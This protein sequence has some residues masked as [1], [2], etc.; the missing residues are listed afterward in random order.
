MGQVWCLIVSIPDLCTLAYFS[1]SR[2]CGLVAQG[3]TLIFSC[4]RGIGSFL[5]VQNFEFQYNLGGFQKNKYFLEYE[6]FVDIFW[7]C[8][9][10]GL[11]LGVISMHFRV[12]S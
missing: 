10:I 12:D 6:D 11:Y 5:G 4:I 3:D 9:K 1:S 2:C 8:H 7:G